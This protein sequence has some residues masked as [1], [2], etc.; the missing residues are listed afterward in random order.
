MTA[1]MLMRMV[2]KRS[3]AVSSFFS[4]YLGTEAPP[5]CSSGYSSNR[6]I[7]DGM[8][9]QGERFATALFDT[10]QKIEIVRAVIDFGV[11]YVRLLI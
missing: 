8:L 1:R 6:N 2:G 10:A 5:L 9:R 4:V 3:Q 11:G 7:T